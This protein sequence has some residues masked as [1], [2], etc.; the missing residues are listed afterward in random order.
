MAKDLIKKASDEPPIEYITTGFKELDEIVMFPRKR[1]TEVYGLQS[2]GKTSLMLR[3][4][5]GLIAEG[6][7]VLYIDVENSFNKYRA[8]ALGIDLD[9]LDI[10]VTFTVED[11]MELIVENV[12]NYDAI[13][14]DSVAAMIPRAEMEGKPGDANMG[15]KARL[16]GQL[17]RMVSQP[18]H[19]SQCALV[20][21]N[22]LRENMEMFSAKYSTPGGMA[23]KFSASLRIEL[24]TYSKDKIIRDGV[25]AGHWINATVTKSKIGKPH[26]TARFKLMYG[27]EQ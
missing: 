3:S 13:V 20:F 15:L 25:Q 22:Q 4:L 1:I 26:L 18:L 2:V 9:K 6:H 7:K 10:A 17:M 11:I 14:V 27:E 12:G 24:K 19:K 21:I 16:M 5:A 8:E 23:L